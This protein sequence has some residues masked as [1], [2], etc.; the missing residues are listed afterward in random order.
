MCVTAHQA[1][2]ASSYAPW[3]KNHTSSLLLGLPSQA[4]MEQ[5]AIQRL[6]ILLEHKPQLLQPAIVGGAESG[7]HEVEVK[8]L[9]E[10][11]RNLP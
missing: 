4:T 5:Q 8:V 3:N 9:A 1:L 10:P 6:P 7:L 2:R 11:Q